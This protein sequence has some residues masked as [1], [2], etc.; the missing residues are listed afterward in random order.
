MIRATN[1]SKRYLIYPRPLDRLRDWFAP[2]NRKRGKPFWALRDINLEVERGSSL[3]VV[4]V[5]GAGKTTLLKLLAGTTVPTEGTFSVEGRVSALLEL[6]MGFHP[7]F[8]GRENIAFNGKMLGLSEGELKE[9][10]PAILEFSEIGD[11]VDQPLRTYSSG[12]SLRLAFAIAASVEPDVLI[13]DEALSV[14]DLHFQQ[15][16]LA[17]IRQ[18]QERG[19]TV[20]FVSH[21]PALVKSFCDEAILL[22][23]GRLLDHGKPDQVLDY[24]NALL[25]EK[26]RD[27]GSQVRIIRPALSERQGDEETGRRGDGKHETEEATP[28]SE[29]RNPQSTIFNPQSAGGHRVGNFQ[30]VITRVQIQGN[31]LSGNAKL[32]LPGATATITVRVVALENVADPTIGILIKDRIGNEVY[33]INTH[34]RGHRIGPLAAGKSVEVQFTAPMNLGVGMYS[35][36]AAIHEG[37]THTEICY[38]WIDHAETFQILP[39]PADPFIGGCRLETTIE[40]REVEVSVEELRQVEALRSGRAN[41]ESPE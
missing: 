7:E 37:P 5:N 4:G 15:K 32:F 23:G 35:I 9:R 38:D 41:R 24:Y 39:T 22:D 10:T 11:F 19:V 31:G 40:H 8:T 20:L 13:V 33:G 14:G 12:M 16:C 3:G 17:R 30:A 18:F 21:D 25:A 28:Q 26:Y 36:T 34:L 27:Q 1:L 2:E 6:G 29:I